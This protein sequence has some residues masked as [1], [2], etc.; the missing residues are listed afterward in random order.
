MEFFFYE[1]DEMEICLRNGAT[2][3]IYYKPVCYC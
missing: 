3:N 1:M 2:Q